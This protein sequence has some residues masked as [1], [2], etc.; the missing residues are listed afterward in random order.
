MAKIYFALAPALANNGVINY[1]TSE[2]IKIISA[3]AS[4]LVDDPLFG[5]EA[6][7]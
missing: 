5:C 3:A 1:S 4:V 6:N 2:G 7:G